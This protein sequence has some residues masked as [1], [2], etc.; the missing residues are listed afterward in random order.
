M[1]SF[2]RAA[3][4]FKDRAEFYHVYIEEAHP[5]DGWSIPGMNGEWN[6]NEARS[7]TERAE[8]ARA[9]FR[10]MQSASTVLVDGVEGAVNDAFAARPERL[11]IL[12]GGNVVYRGGEGPF[13]YNMDECVRELRALVASK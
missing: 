7:T 13:N 10:K 11:Y 2:E 1:P 8:T 9:F 5:R 12:A 3:R 4:E 6:V